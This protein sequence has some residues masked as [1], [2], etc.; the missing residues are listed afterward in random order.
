MI[1]ARVM[2][3]HDQALLL[4][5]L[6][7]TARPIGEVAAELDWSISRV[8]MVARELGCTAVTRSRVMLAVET[9]SLGPIGALKRGAMQAVTQFKLFECTE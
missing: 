3:N 2:G 8:Q 6:T 9:V 7:E 1:G 4:D 5:V